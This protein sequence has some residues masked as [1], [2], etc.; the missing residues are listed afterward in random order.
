M[1]LQPIPKSLVTF[2]P[3]H[4]GV[5]TADSVSFLVANLS[6]AINVIVK[7]LQRPPGPARHFVYFP[8]QITRLG[9][10]TFFDPFF[11]VCALSG[12]SAL[13]LVPCRVGTDLTPKHV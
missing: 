8:K 9:R 7:S 13:R 4:P 1:L 10:K 5:L 12:A 2:P 11:H 3:K 6:V